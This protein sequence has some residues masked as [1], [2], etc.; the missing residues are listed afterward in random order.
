M[1]A[2]WVG[3][4]P[5]PSKGLGLLQMPPDGLGTGKDRNAIASPRGRGN[6]RGVTG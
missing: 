5:A 4:P 2:R 1:R 3:D 6:R